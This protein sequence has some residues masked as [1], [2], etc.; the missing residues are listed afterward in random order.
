MEEDAVV[1]GEACPFEAAVSV[2]EDLPLIVA[3]H[4]EV[5]A[6]VEFADPA[7]EANPVERADPVDDIS[8]SSDYSPDYRT[9]VKISKVSLY[10]ID[11][12]FSLSF[13]A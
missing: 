4:V 8:S 5:T 7:E 11:S 9:Y 2:E 1:E 13:I 10:M 6:H 3:A 12:L